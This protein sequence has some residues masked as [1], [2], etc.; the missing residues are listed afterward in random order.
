M[1]NKWIVLFLSAM[2]A[3]SGCQSPV[4][5]QAVANVA[6]VKIKTDK[7]RKKSDDS[8]KPSPSLL[9]KQGDYVDTTPISLY[10]KP[11]WLKNHIEIRGDAL[12]FSYYSRVIAAGAGAGILTKYQ[13][14]LDPAVRVSINYAGTVEGA[15][16][17]LATKAGYVYSVTGNKVYWQAFLTRTFD[18][19]FM[20][21]GTDYMMG[22]AAGGGSSS[23]TTGSG[24]GG[25]GGSTISFGNDAADA[26]YS[27]ISG[28]LSLWDDLRTTVE[29]LLSP[30]GKVTVSQATT[31]VT[32]RDRPTNVDL[33]GQYIRNLNT[34]LSK[35]VLIKIQ[36]LEV[37]LE[38]TFNF[39]INWDLIA[40]AFNQSPFI[41]KGNYGTPIAISA[42]TSQTGSLTTPQFGTQGS[43][44]TP[45][46][47]ILFNALNQQGKTSVVSEPRVVCLN[48]QVSVVRI[49]ETEGYV[50][51]IENT[52][53][54]AGGTS[55]AAQNTVT[56]QVTPGTLVTGLTLYVLPKIMGKQI[57]MQVNADL[58]TKIRIQTF[59]SGSSRVQLPNVQAKHFNQRSVIKSGDTLI[60][61]GF[62]QLSN[63]ANAN[64]LLRSQALGGKA[65]IQD[66]S[67]TVVLITPIILTGGA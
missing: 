39:G 10:K 18:V 42:L 62:R 24:G 20:P 50:A 16:D 23:A 36:I 25:S 65:A 55:T 63:A 57:Y 8:A 59:G 32:V 14:G 7:A 28:K 37:N 3:L 41:L 51:S 47:T 21:G 9:V 2:L 38:N 43:G 40:N 22:K 19:A 54:G 31:S 27:N 48:N 6:D 64:Q 53:T 44:K 11:A 66:S 5:D 4:Y 35:Q 45:S 60:M 13:T 56:S 26:E 46:Y 29:Q 30:D 1:L 34:N 67:E 58:S 15:L 12:P 49:T 61:S 33:I 17:M 52:S